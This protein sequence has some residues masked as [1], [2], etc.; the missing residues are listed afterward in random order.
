MSNLALVIEDN[1]DLAIIFTEALQ[2]AGFETETILDGSKAAE[3]LAAVTPEVVVLDLHLPNVSGREILKQIQTDA[4]LAGTH[5]ILATA[6]ARLADMM[7]NEADLVLVKPVSFS[8]LRDL[9]KRLKPAA[10][11]DK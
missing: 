5:V 8:Q 6:D 11:P 3:R 10:P 7:E 9:V 2:V 1:T 4:R